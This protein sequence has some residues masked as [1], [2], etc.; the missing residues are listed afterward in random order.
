M[1][2]TLNSQSP[3]L[4]STNSDELVR[5]ITKREYVEKLLIDI[6][7]KSNGRTDSLRKR[8]YEGLL[9]F[10]V[11]SDDDDKIMSSFK[12]RAKDKVE[13]YDDILV[14]YRINPKYPCKRLMEDARKRLCRNP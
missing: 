5:Y 12:S 4:L 14:E 10:T 7:R 9:G 6:R 11:S 8:S 13:V 2:L 3:S 1:S